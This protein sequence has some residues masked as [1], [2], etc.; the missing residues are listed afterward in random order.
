[1]SH[2]ARRLYDSP[3]SNI[4]TLE[5]WIFWLNNRSIISSLLVFLRFWNLNVEMNKKVLFAIC[6]CVLIVAVT[7]CVVVQLV[8]I[9]DEMNANDKNH[10]ELLINHTLLNTSEPSINNT[11]T[12]EIQPD[13]EFNEA[14]AND[15]LSDPLSS[16]ME[17]ESTKNST[18][19]NSTH[20][21]GASIGDMAFSPFVVIHAPVP[22][23]QGYQY[24]AAKNKCERV[25]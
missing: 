5:N 14:S 16:T 12:L 8:W 9:R 24:V 19:D 10:Q 2:E 20:L 15:P 7:V 3:L 13:I 6:A 17:D 21:V 22:C 25:L 18:E 4:C 23:R 11:E 1:M